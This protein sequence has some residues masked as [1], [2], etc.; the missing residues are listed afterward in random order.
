VAPAPKH[1]GIFR[2][3]GVSGLIEWV[4][5]NPSVKKWY[6]KISTRRKGTGEAYASNLWRYWKGSLS[7]KYT[8]IDDWAAQTKIQVRTA[9][10]DDDVST[11]WADNLEAFYTST[12]LRESS[13]L[14]LV[15]AI[16]SYLSEG[17]KIKLPEVKFHLESEGMPEEHH[18]PVLTSDELAILVNKANTRDKALILTQV[19]AGFGV[20][21][22][23][24]FCN[25]W[26]DYQKKI[27]EKAVPIRV[28]M[29][30]PKTHVRYW[31]LLWHDAVDALNALI[32][33]RSGQEPLFV[34]QFGK[35]M[36]KKD[37]QDSVRR[38][39]DITKLE[40]SKEG[41]QIYRIRP[42]A[43]RH[44]IRT[45]CSNAEVNPEISE[46]ILGHE[47][48][49][50]HYNQFMET[51]Q[52]EELI[53][54][55]MRKVAPVL[56]VLTGRGRQIVGESYLDRTIDTWATVDGTDPEALKDRIAYYAKRLKPKDFIGVLEQM[57][58]EQEYVGE[59]T[60]EEMLSNPPREVAI[61]ALRRL[62]KE[63]L[64]PLFI[65]M[66]RD[67]KERSYVAEQK[68]IQKIIS[69]TE[70]ERYLEDGW[71]F[72][73]VINSEK[74]LVEKLPAD[75]PPKVEKGA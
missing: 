30:R 67:K 63:Q 36:T 45:A 42:H 26:H 59:A 50:L 49:E 3:K 61:E 1:R 46:F 35:P 66:A 10:A 13:R 41:T 2:Q 33:E 71:T 44:Y 15:Q 53:R 56:N 22:L 48:D 29:R 62:T 28:D 27:K 72:R 11:N 54:A 47:V 52:G 57:V 23:L 70:L 43:I 20:G 5:A 17:A 19:S 40:P 9:N 34:N 12:T 68:P 8:S 14:V 55:K 25:E 7:S 75:L 64:Q 16:K 18:Y 6:D 31:S 4:E 32:L 73:S 24:R 65:A 58:K 39:A 37:Y 21:E 38:L 74:V 51:K 69:E 60:P